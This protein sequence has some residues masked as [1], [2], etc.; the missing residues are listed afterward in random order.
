MMPMPV[1]RTP[2]SMKD[3]AKALIRTLRSGGVEPTKEAAGVF[4]AQYA[5][6]TGAGGFCWNHNLF[7]HKVTQAMVN[8]GVPYMQLANTWEIIDGKRVTFQPP[9]PATWFRAFASFEASMSHHITAIKTGRYASSWP[10]VLAGDPE[11][12]AAKIR[13]KGYY[14]A[15]LADYVRLIRAKFNAWMAAPAFD[16]AMAELDEASEATTDPAIRIDLVP[17]EPPPAALSRFDEALAADRQ[18]LRD[19]RDSEPPPPDDAA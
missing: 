8:S 17:S 3:F 7:N 1:I 18:R 10:A 14:T 6:E 12:Y 5:L 9:H 4:W 2:I 15:P 16:D 11:L 19:E 13:E